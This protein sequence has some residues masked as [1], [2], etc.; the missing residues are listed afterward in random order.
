VAGAP[1][2]TYLFSDIEGS[3]RLWESDADGAARAVAWHDDVSRNA[4][5]S[6]G[7]TIV[8]MTGDGMHA[9]F[10]DP[11]NAI[12]AVIDLQMALACPA[13]GTPPLQVRCGLHL[14]ADQRRDNDFFGPAVNRAARIMGAAHGGQ[15]LVSQAVAERVASSLPQGTTLR[16]L[17]RVRLK[18]LANPESLYQLLHPSLRTEFPALRSLASTPNNLP[19]QL[20]SFV[21]RERE[22]AEVRALLA[23]SRLVTLLAMGGVGKSRL[24]VQ[25]GAEVLDDYPDGVWL[26]ELAP[27]M[28][29]VALP[30]AVATALGVREEPGGE[31][32]EALRAYVRNR[33]LLLLLDNCEHL[34]QAC[35]ELSKNLLQASVAMKVLATSR[36][37]LQIA[38]ETIYQLPTL[39]A[40]GTAPS[41]PAQLLELEAVRLF[42][43]RVSAARHGFELNERNATSVASICRRLDGIPLALELAAARTRSL[44]V[45][46]IA[47]RLDD[48]FRLL[49]S[50]DRTA[51][52]RQKTLRAL[53]DW[54]YD[55]LTED[56]RQLFQR[57]AVF[58]GGWTVESAEAVCA[59]DGIAS[60]R[61]LDL[62]SQLVE[63]SLAIVDASGERYRM[64]ETVRHYAAERL[65]EVHGEAAT[66][67]RHLAFFVGLVER[68]LDFLHGPSQGI[69]LQKL[70]A[71][72][73]NIVW[74][75]AWCDRSPMGAESSV[76]LVSALKYYWLNRGML[77]AGYASA[78]TAVEQARAGSSPAV[79]KRALVNAGTIATFLGRYRDARDHLEAALALVEEPEDGPQKVATLLLL[80]EADL[81]LGDASGALHRCEQAVALARSGI[82][83]P[84]DLATAINAKAQLLRVSDRV[85]EASVLYREAFAIARSLGDDEN[86]AVSLLNLAIVDVLRANPKGALRA[87]SQVIEIQAR[88]RS[89]AAGQSVLEVCAGLAGLTGELATAAEFLGAAEA[90]ATRSGLRRDPADEAFFQSVAER[91][92]AALG[93]SAT[94]HES[95][96]RELTYDEA[97]DQ[98]VRW[99]QSCASAE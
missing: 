54:S 62:L 63:K 83:N 29:E 48:R 24:S 18:D 93:P 94:E 44:S 5:R 96:G 46:A 31:I 95:T 66:R 8:K 26:V 11:R 53:I 72:R 98:A 70:D 1:T 88:I 69:W 59:G 78:R 79:L 74:A 86:E 28:D 60:D 61:V 32:L 77:G 71:E 7:G 73:E 33:R 65:R 36:D 25:L 41:S 40:P 75:Q 13:V 92:R 17:G 10:D 90:Q 49:V 91:V 37:S 12:A 2:V 58:P 38:G 57:L 3:T 84:R 80:G 45:E 55:L 21:G 82:G 43:D 4:V 68:A 9:A 15:I 85:D 16:E 51:L 39:S 47:E 76:R 42:V 56:E 35:A 81:A 64:L 52:P 22:M 99:V 87:L 67:E 6:H 14:G 34:V 19:Q 27:L 50:G 97:M 20:N 23:K 89:Q 30:H